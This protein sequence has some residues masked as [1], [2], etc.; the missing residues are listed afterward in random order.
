M[1]STAVWMFYKILG[2]E[3]IKTSKK[4]YRKSFEAQIIG[5]HKIVFCF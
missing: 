2:D 4:N 1:F 5:Q 3:N